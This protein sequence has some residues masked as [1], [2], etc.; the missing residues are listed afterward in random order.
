MN[1]S[2]GITTEQLAAPIGVKPQSIRV[3]LCQTGSYFGLTPN[4]L[5]NGRLLWP[6]D[7]VARLLEA[8][9]GAA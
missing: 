3:R 9:G 1:Y 2:T 8:K 7:S 5:P 6:A 4:K